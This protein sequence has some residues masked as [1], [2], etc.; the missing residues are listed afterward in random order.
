MQS[1]T[2]LGGSG[3]GSSKERA[4]EVGSNNVASSFTSQD[5][6]LAQ[7]PQAQ[8]ILLQTRHALDS[9]N[10]QLLPA[11]LADEVQGIPQDQADGLQSIDQK[12][13]QQQKAASALAKYQEFIRR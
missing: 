12:Q 9:S 5:N 10:Q 2:P 11:L 13:S 4:T 1:L 8:Q 6:G 3:N 7:A